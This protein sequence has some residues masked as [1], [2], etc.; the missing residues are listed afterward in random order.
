M[1]TLIGEIKAGTAR[2]AKVTF[3]PYLNTNFISGDAT[4]TWNKA[5]AEKF[6]AE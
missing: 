2:E 5:D 6:K 1:R 3:G 4:I